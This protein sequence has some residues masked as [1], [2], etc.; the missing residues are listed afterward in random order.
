MSSYRA[1]VRIIKQ[2]HQSQNGHYKPTIFYLWSFLT[3]DVSL[4]LFFAPSIVFWGN[5][6]RDDSPVLKM[7]HK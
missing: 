7:Q 1:A 4:A 6:S 2:Y 5:K 3:P